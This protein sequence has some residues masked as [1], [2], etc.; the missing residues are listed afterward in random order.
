M[1]SILKKLILLI[2]MILV[3]LLVT[4]DLFI[5][6]MDSSELALLQTGRAGTVLRCLVQQPE[7]RLWWRNLRPDG[8]DIIL[9]Q[10]AH[11]LLNVLET[12]QPIDMHVQAR[13]SGSLLLQGF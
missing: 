3:G 9:D 12:T 13:L 10:E 8:Q 5:P 4:R 7:D 11:L 6:D 2:W 1:Q